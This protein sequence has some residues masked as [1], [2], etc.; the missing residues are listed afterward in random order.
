MKQITL[1]IR[2][3]DLLY[4]I[5]TEWMEEMDLDLDLNMGIDHMGMRMCVISLVSDSKCKL[6]GY[7]SNE[8]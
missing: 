7:S 2:F 1:N 6:N 8:L 3:R 4:F 5:Y